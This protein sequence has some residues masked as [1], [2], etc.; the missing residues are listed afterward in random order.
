MSRNR[1]RLNGLHTGMAQEE[2]LQHMGKPWRTDSFLENEQTYLVL[3]YVTQRIPD[4][5]TTDEEM[6]PVMIREGILVGW[7]RQFF[8]DLRVEVK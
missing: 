5:T 8:S 6:T 7:G 4:G 2:V 1:D 3:Y